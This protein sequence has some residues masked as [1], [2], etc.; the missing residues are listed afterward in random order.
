M[1]I[2]IVDRAFVLVRHP[3][4]GWLV[5]QGA[6][7][8]LPGGGVEKRESLTRGALRELW[9]ETGIRANPEDL[10]FVDTIDHRALFLLSLPSL[11]VEIVLSDEH[12]DYH[13][14][15]TKD[16]LCVRWLRKKHLKK[17]RQLHAQSRSP[18]TA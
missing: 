10:V 8:Q 12:T 2:R 5:M 3:L 15:D 6:T 7:W 11:P 17:A 16:V 4:R 13:W 18:H 1:S 14:V 9:E